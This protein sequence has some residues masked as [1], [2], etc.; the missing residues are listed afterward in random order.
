MLIIAFG[1][2]SFGEGGTGD[3]VSDIKVFL[4]VFLNFFGNFSGIF[5]FFFVKEI[6][7]IFF[8]IFCI[9]D[10]LCLMEH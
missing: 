9:M 8:R 3:V 7:L 10:V 6:F 1:Y 4:N 2:S 5:W